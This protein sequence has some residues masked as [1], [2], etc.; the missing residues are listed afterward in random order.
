MRYKVTG[1]SN[2]DA[3][4]N[5]LQAELNTQLDD[6]NEIIKEGIELLVKQIPDVLGDVWLHNVKF[7]RVGGVTWHLSDE[8]NELV[9]IGPLK[10]R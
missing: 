10:R 1:W 5:P 9:T 3:K 2:E 4:L 7:W 6:K 8:L